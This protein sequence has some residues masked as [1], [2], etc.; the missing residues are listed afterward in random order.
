MGD[1]NYILVRTLVEGSATIEWMSSVSLGARANGLVALDTALGANAASACARVDTL[2]IEASLGGA[3]LLVLRALGVA[4][5]ERIAQEVGR[6]RANCAMVLN[7]IIICIIISKRNLVI[8]ARKRM[9][10]CVLNSYP[11][12]TIGISSA[13]AARILTTEVHT[14]SVGIT[15]EIGFAFTTTSLDR[16]AHESFLTGADSTTVL[17][18]T[19]GV[20]SAR[21]WGTIIAAYLPMIGNLKMRNKDLGKKKFLIH[22]L[23]AEDT[24]AG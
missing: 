20:G 1:S 13:G 18:T 5:G 14:S 6:A 12:V 11:D 15:F 16:I 17:D 23:S 19:F 3:A 24:G 4:S 21:R 2:E 9:G 22:T 10:I 7:K 8:D